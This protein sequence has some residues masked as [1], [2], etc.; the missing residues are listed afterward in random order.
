LQL[1]A[2]CMLDICNHAYTSEYAAYIWTSELD[3]N[4]PT[5][6]Q[7]TYTIGAYREGM[8]PYGRAWR[9]LA[10]ARVP[11]I[12]QW[13]LASTFSESCVL[14]GFQSL[15]VTVTMHFDVHNLPC[16]IVFGCT[17]GGGVR[18]GKPCNLVQN[19]CWTYASM[20]IHLNTQHTYE[21][22]NLT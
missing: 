21:L 19:A 22:L 8:V 2:E 10:T 6:M 5:T 3:L 7:S 4:S 14:H 13:F 12:L 15:H 9:T 18:P 20:H 17:P 1:G 11:C 16:L